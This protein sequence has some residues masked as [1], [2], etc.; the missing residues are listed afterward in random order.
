MDVVQETARL[1][2]APVIHAS[3]CNRFSCKN[4]GFPF[5]LYKGVLEGNA[6][7]VD[8]KGNILARRRKEEGEGIVTAEIT[9][10]NN[11]SNENIP[12]RFWLRN[13]SVLPTIAWHYQGFLGKLWYQKKIKAMA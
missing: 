1:V 4:L 2:G 13:R 11:N 8:A 5:Q 12:D 9:L 6:A 7:I 3:H 10:E